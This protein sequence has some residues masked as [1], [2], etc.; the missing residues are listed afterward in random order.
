[1]S[2]NKRKFGYNIYENLGN[3]KVVNVNDPILDP[4]K[5]Y[6]LFYVF[7]LKILMK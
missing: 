5:K 7:L 1:M 4:N 2:G 3:N 6:I